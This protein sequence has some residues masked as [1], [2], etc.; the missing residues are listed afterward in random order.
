MFQKKFL[1]D[2]LIDFSEITMET[3]KILQRMSPFGLGNKKP[4]FRTNNCFLDHTLKFVGKESQIVKSKIKDKSGKELSFISFDNKDALVNIKS[5]F[6]I[7]YTVDVNSYSGKDEIQL[8]L[9]E[10]YLK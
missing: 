10:I 3:V 1:Y 2:L 4:V 6:D 7:L 5:T 9:R 8:M